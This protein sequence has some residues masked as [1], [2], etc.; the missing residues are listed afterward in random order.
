MSTAISPY[1]LS[2]YQQRVLCLV[3]KFRFVTVPLLQ[4]YLRLKRPSTIRNT[5]QTLELNG[6]LSRL[7]DSSYTID[8]KP[9]LYILS[10]KGLRLMKND[11]TNDA[12]VI[13]SYYKNK[14]LSDAFMQH[15]LA[16]LQV[17]TA[18]R[19]R[20]GDQLCPA[21]F[22]KAEVAGVVDFPAP[23][24]DLYVR[25]KTS[26]NEYF[27]ELIYDQLPFLVR[28]RLAAL[29]AHSEEEGWVAGQYPTLLFVCQSVRQQDR[30]LAD[31]QS[32]LDEVG[33]PY[34]ELPIGVT[35]LE[36]LLNAEAEADIWRLVDADHP[37]G[38]LVG[39]ALPN[40]D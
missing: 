11:P 7:Y 37:R 17:C 38:Q 21:F 5:L 40:L 29:I 24:P 9:A 32:L 26:T 25:S 35:T 15:Q 19:K 6:Y 3:F 13:H 39:G 27:I 22:T 20:T 23:P 31:A 10:P 33:V 8:R 14:H 36:T 12:G 28:K 2:A 1:R 16:I 30:C 34:E 18:L 4:E